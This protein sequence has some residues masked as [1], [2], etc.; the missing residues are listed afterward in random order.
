MGCPMAW[1]GQMLKPFLKIP[2]RPVQSNDQLK[3]IN[4]NLADIKRSWKMIGL[5]LDE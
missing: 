5:D 3:P 4:S 2:S 1:C